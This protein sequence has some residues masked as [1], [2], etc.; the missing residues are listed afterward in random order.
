MP[1]SLS[2][3]A[4]KRRKQPQGRS[5]PVL[6]D[7]KQV[8]N[9]QREAFRRRLLP[10]GIKPANRQAARGF[11]SHSTGRARSLPTPCD[12]CAGVAS[13]MSCPS[14][15]A[16]S[17][18]DLL[19]RRSVRYCERSGVTSSAKPAST[20]EAKRRQPEL[21]GRL[22]AHPRYRQALSSRQPLLLASRALLST[23]A[24]PLACGPLLSRRLAS[25]TFA[26][27]ARRSG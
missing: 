17:T 10:G 27:A 26:G 13:G 12:C 25:D 7:R 1:A 14:S 5:V 15:S 19:P 8:T 11:A 6:P 4:R 23:L 24:A 18:A 9:R 16:N 2:D 22:P 21:S 3:R 20:V